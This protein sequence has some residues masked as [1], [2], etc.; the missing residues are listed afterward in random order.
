MQAPGDIPVDQVEYL[1]HHQ[2]MMEGVTQ[3][4]VDVLQTIKP[5]QPI[6]KTQQQHYTRLG[7]VLR[8]MLRPYEAGML[9][10]HCTAHVLVAMNASMPV[11][12]NDGSTPPSARLM[13]EHHCV[14]L[15]AFVQGGRVAPMPLIGT[16]YRVSFR[17][18]LTDW[19]HGAEC[20]STYVKVQQ[21]CLISICYVDSYSC[22]E[23][24]CP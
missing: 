7:N 19:F 18:I 12:I 9:V 1:R 5:M 17:F 20:P 21:G 23:A 10:R 15:L 2:V 6:I 16:A 11:L 13:F 8:G 4:V 22:T 14:L 24:M 3:G